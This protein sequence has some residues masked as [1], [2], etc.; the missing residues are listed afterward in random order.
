MAEVKKHTAQ[1]RGTAARRGHS[2]SLY[3]E[4]PVG[5]LHRTTTVSDPSHHTTG[6]HIWP[7][8]TRNRVA[9]STTPGLKISHTITTPRQ[10]D[11]TPD[12]HESGTGLAGLNHTPAGSHSTSSP[13]HS[14]TLSGAAHW[15]HDGST[16]PIQHTTSCTPGTEG[17]QRN[18]TD[19]PLQ[20]GTVNTHRARAEQHQLTV[21]RQD[22]GSSCRTGAQEHGQHAPPRAVGH[23]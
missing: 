7:V 6:S 9:L 16:A 14:S 10:Q 11:S 12:T 5:Q 22:L 21:C 4:T 18:T 23:Y 1:Q 19:S 3:R 17:A 20:H 8:W 13:P 15:Q 2:D